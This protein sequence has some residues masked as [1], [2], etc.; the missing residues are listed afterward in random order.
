MRLWT[1]HQAAACCVVL[2]SFLYICNG[3]QASLS[4]S[5]GLPCKQAGHFLDISTL[6]CK[7]CDQV[8]HLIGS[9]ISHKGFQNLHSVVLEAS[10]SRAH[11]H[12]LCCCAGRWVCP[13]S[14]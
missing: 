9:R 3:Q 6:E 1:T 8:M 13:I 4:V 12:Q 2:V 5:A 10:Q 14:R 11:C 7:A